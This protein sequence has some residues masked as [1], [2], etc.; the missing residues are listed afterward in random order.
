MK[1]KIKKEKTGGEKVRRFPRFYVLDAVIILLIVA[2]ILG[3]YFRYSIFDM[4]GNSRNQV[5]VEVSFSIKNI[6]DTTSHYIDI[7]DSVYVKGEGT[8]MGVLLAS[9]DNSDM[10]L[11]N[12]APASATFVKNGE[13]INVNYPSETRIDA[14]G[15]LLCKGIFAQDGAFMLNG[16]QYLSAG[17]VLT[18]CTEKV[19][20]EITVLN[21]EKVV[22]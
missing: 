9:D 4:F 13:V 22:N 8:Q 18:V 7:G 17:Q 21:I 3:I 6:K 1:N 5:D 15:R 20:V 10:P 19:T 12:I 2:V 11:G 16:D 14:E